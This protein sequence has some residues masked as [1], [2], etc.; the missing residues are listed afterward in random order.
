MGDCVIACSYTHF[1]HETVELLNID[2]RGVCKFDS[3][4]DR[5]FVTLGN[6]LVATVDD[7]VGECAEISPILSTAICF[8]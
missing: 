6:S 4:L 7:V 3:P 8:Y 2:H 1:Q 5:N